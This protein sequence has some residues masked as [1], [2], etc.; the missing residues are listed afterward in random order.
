MVDMHRGIDHGATMCN[1]RRCCSTGTIQFTQV[2]FLMLRLQTYLYYF[3]FIYITWFFF[4]WKCTDGQEGIY[5]LSYPLFSCFCTFYFF[6]LSGCD[7][8]VLLLWLW[9]DY[10][11]MY[12]HK[13]FGKL[14]ISNDNL[15]C[16][17][18]QSQQPFLACQGSQAD[19]H[20]Y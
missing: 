6:N 9:H 12:E 11:K 5:F 18:I 7:W 1:H 10:L 19:I 13:L 15:P 8:F 4:L 14:W 17:N 20:T 16:H 2:W 3:P